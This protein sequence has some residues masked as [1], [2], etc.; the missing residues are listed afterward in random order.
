MN[1][2]PSDERPV[3]IAYS[4]GRKAARG[5]HEIET[6]LELARQIAALMGASFAGEF[7]PARQYPANR[8]LIPDDTLDSHDARRL[9]LASERNLYG[10]V[11]PFPF[12]GTKVVVHGLPPG[13]HEAPEGWASGFGERVSG[14]VLPGFSAFTR[15]DAHA[16]ASLLWRDGAVRLKRPSGIGGTGQAVVADR[17]ALDAQLDDIGEEALRAEG[18]VLERDL[19]DIETLSVGRAC[20]GG[21]EASYYGVQRLTTNNHGHQVYGGSDL[22]VVRGGFDALSCIDMPAEAQ[23]AIEQSRAFDEAVSD[24]FDGFFASRRNYDVGSGTDARGQTYRGVLEQSWRIGGAS[25][26][27][28]GAL[29][30]LRDD[31]AVRIVRASTTEIYG[32]NAA[33][34]ADACV[35]YHGIDPHAGE[36]TK[37]CTVDG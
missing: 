20:L 37:Y 16:A 13:A 19:Q 7:D 5:R 3:V 27:E 31:P 15:G 10:G 1:A 28:I 34:P 24:T 32:A 4:Q 33:V 29:K 26:A 18:V 30:A 22:V 17:A 9:G 12:V 23:T 11:V 35:Y 25:G 36:I 21:L 6:Q 14:I 8:Y 2:L